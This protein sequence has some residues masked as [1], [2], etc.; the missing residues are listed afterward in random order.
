MSVPDSFLF[1]RLTS[2]IPVR[3]VSTLERAEY[4]ERLQDVLRLFDID[5]VSD[6]RGIHF[7]GPGVGEED[8][9]LVAALTTLVSRRFGTW[10]PLPEL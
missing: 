7:D 8:Q 6:G 4:V 9:P 10:A 1:E 3:V 5:A 2:I